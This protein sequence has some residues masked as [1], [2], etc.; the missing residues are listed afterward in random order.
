MDWSFFSTQL[1]SPS[2]PTS[3][4]I[5]S[6]GCNSFNLLPSLG[7]HTTFV[8]NRAERGTCVTHPFTLTARMSQIGKLYIPATKQTGEK[9]NEKAMKNFGPNSGHFLIRI[10]FSPRPS[11][12]PLVPRFRPILGF[13]EF[14]S[15]SEQKMNKQQQQQQQRQ[16]SRRKL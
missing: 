9:I 4:S 7:A 8:N 12:L 10:S 6:E 16:H 5:F 3:M 2:S 11:P 13:Y 15:K 1:S 14:G